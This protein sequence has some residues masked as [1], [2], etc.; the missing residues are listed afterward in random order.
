MSTAPLITL[1]REQLEQLEW[2]ASSHPEDA[3][4]PVCNADKPTHDAGC[5]LGELLHGDKRE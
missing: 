3:L 4:C 5:W 1:T 2:A